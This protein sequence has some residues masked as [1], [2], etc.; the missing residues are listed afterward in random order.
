MNWLLGCIAALILGSLVCG[1][2]MGVTS[3][4]MLKPGESY[5]EYYDAA[6]P[7]DRTERDRL[8]GS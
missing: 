6:G 3:R 2:G 5:H 8:R 7:A 4:P 1:C